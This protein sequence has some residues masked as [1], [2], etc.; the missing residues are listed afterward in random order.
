MFLRDLRNRKTKGLNQNS[1][2][3]TSERIKSSECNCLECTFSCC[4]M[5]G[6]PVLIVAGKKI[7]LKNEKG[8]LMLSE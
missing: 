4:I 1:M 5:D 7:H 6:S 2:Q 8:V 3:Y